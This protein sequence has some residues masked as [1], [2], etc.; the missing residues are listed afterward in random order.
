MLIV[1]KLNFVM[2]RV[3]TTT[4]SM[5]TMSIITLRLKD[6]YGTLSLNDIQHKQQ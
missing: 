5:T 3:G 2:L 6:L 1:V 4:L